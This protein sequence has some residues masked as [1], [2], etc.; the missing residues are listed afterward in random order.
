MGSRDV[1]PTPVQI[2]EKKRDGRK[3]DENDI[4]AFVDYVTVPEGQ[5]R[6]MDD[7]QIG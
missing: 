2:I 1:L 7:S 6:M 5:P 4:R 3:L